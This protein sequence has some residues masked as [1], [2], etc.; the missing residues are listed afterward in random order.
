MRVLV[1]TRVGSKHF[2]VPLQRLGCD[3]VHA[4]LDA[5]D[6][7]WTGKGEGDRPVRCGIEMKLIPDLLQS[8]DSGRLVGRQLPAMHA[9][10]EKSWLLVVGEVQPSKRGGLLEMKLVEGGGWKEP[11]GRS[12]TYSE[13]EKRLHTI[14][15]RGGVQVV[16]VPHPRAAVWW[17]YSTSKWWEAGWDKHKSFRALYSHVSGVQD[18]DPKVDM[19]ELGPFEGERLLRHMAAQLPGIGWERSREVLEVFSTPRQMVTAGVGDWRR[20]KGIGKLL[21]ARF[22]RLLGGGKL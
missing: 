19:Q 16:R 12:W 20:V 7:C 15:Q 9:Q 10:Y 17:L 14:S 1:D 6:F 2:L 11:R 22:V 18:D 5:G 3:A 8:M 13:F 4:T 21:A